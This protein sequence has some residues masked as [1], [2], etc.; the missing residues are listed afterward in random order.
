MLVISSNI[1]SLNAQRNLS[2]SQSALERSLQRLSSGQRINSSKDDAAGL[3]ISERMTAQIRGLNQAARNANDGISLAQTVDSSLGEVTNNLQRVREL[4][5]QAINATNSASDRAALDIEV[6]DRL[7]E[8]D[9]L[10]KQANFNGRNILD[11]SFGAEFLQ[12]GSNAGQTIRIDLAEDMRL[13]NLGIASS[14]AGNNTVGN[15]LT[16]ATGNLGTAKIASSANKTSGGANAYAASAPGSYAGVS[17]SAFNGSNFSLNGQNVLASSGFVGSAAGQD[18]SSAYAKAAAIN[19]SVIDGATATAQTKL[20][21]G[22]TGGTAGSTDFLAMWSQG[23]GSNPGKIDYTLTL[24]GVAVFSFNKNFG[25]SGNIPTSLAS[26]TVGVS[27]QTAINAINTQQSSTGV[28]AS[29]D[30]NGNLQLKATDGRN[31]RVQESLVTDVQGVHPESANVRT[32]F[33]ELVQTGWQADVTQDN[34]YRGQLTLTSKGDL[35]LGGTAS[36]AGFTGSETLTAQ[37]LASADVLNANNSNKTINMVDAALIS[38]ANMRS[39]FGALQNRLD[40]TV[41]SISQSA[42]NLSAARSR[43][44]DADFATETAQLTRLQIL[45]QA[46]TAMLAQANSRPEMVLSLLR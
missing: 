45:Q 34:T 33:S 31:I 38:I 36:T 7:A 10:T 44:Q 27:M 3:A 13:Q 24:N 20:D 15:D 32:A 41:S 8:V 4:A 18:S 2:N 30:T 11:G 22:T 25:D 35:A 19:A 39:T 26:T 17:S 6:K 37:N 46:G 21:F 5:V 29:L 16:S 43:I 14:L 1:A 42:E 40:S 12:V 28:V 23:T 9:R